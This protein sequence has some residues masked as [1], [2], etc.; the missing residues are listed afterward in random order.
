[1]EL[2]IVAYGH[3]VLRE[4]CVD[5]DIRYPDLYQLVQNLWY[6]MYG[7]NGCGLAAPQI[8]VPVRIFV[9]DSKN[10]YDVLE[11]EERELI[12]EGDEG[13]RET[14]INAQIIDRSEENTW[15]DEEGCLS[16]PNLSGDVTRP[17]SI[18]I[19]YLDLYFQ[20]QVKTFH[21]ITARMIQHEY[22]H[23]EGILYLDYLSPRKRSSWKRR[24]KRISEGL[25]VAKYPM[26][27][28]DKTI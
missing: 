9:V 8:N 16:I 21:G 24:L 26:I 15:E 4:K 1:M 5:V 7:A 3:P 2:P 11:E 13:I 6:T 19:S 25:E 17:W 20:P 27:F 12:F 14:F 23:T 28:P 10:T 18:T 22:D